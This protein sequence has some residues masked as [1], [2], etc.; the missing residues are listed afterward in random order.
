MAKKRKNANGEGTIYQCKSGKHKG[1]WIGQLVIGTNPDAGKPKRKSFYGKTRAEVK[2]KMREYQE[3]MAQGLDIMGQ[4]QTFGEW[5]LFWMD[6]YKK[7]ELRLSTWENYMR[8]IKNH[9]YPALGHI[10]LRDLKTDDIQNLYNRMIK[11]GRA[12]AT[13]RRNHQII[14]SCL[15]QAVENR[16]LSWNPAEAAKLPK[17]TDTKVRAMT[18]EEMSKFLSVLQEDR[19]GAAFLCLLGTGLRMGELLALRWQDVDLDKQILHVRQALVR[20]KEKGVYFDEP[21]TEKSKRAIPI[22]GEVVEA[23]KK[24]RI[25]QFQLRLA[26]GEKYQN[27]DLVF[28]TSV[29]T[30]IYPRNFTRKFYKLRDKA[31]IPKDIN[32]HALRHTYATRLLEQGE[33]LKTVQELLGHTDIS[34]TANTYSH[35]SIEVKQKAAAKMDKLLSKKFPLGNKSERKLCIVFWFCKSVALPLHYF[36]D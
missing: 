16:L 31:G 9:I 14:N 29:G 27:H 5:I 13:V 10:P 22:P 2:E 33:N 12:P 4:E 32:L 28:A 35:V 7:I 1:R 34:T 20:T 21:K 15:K 19:W 11:E 18:F 25:Q 17:L 30:P 36:Y 23:L 8:S 6:N 3:E 26:V 24:H